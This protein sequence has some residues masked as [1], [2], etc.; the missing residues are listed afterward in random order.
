MAVMA[1]LRCLQSRS[2]LEQRIEAR[3][4]VL[5][6]AAAEAGNRHVDQT[7]IQSGE[8]LVVEAHLAHPAG[9]E[10]LDQD[11]GPF[12]ETVNDFPSFGRFKIHRYPALALVPAQKGEREMTDRVT[13]HTLDFDYVGPHLRKNH[14]AVGTR[15]IAGKVE[16][17]NSG[18]RPCPARSAWRLAAIGRVIRCLKRSLKARGAA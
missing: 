11:V 2:R 5:R 3:L 1:A 12:G 7:R 18:E 17:Q 13:V 8:G 6:P 14:R 10:I 4:I 16:H 9:P 15:D